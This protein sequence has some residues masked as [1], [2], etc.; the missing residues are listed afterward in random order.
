M[1]LSHITTDLI[2]HDAV[3]QAVDLVRD[4][5]PAN[6]ADFPDAAGPALASALIRELESSALIVTTRQDR[7]D[8]LS[9]ALAEYL[10]TDY[11]VAVWNAPDALPYEQLPNDLE[12]GVRRV[13][14]LHRMRSRDTNRRVW[15]APVNGLMQLLSPPAALADMTLTLRLASRQS[16]DDLHAWATRVGYETSPIVQEPGTIARRGGIVDI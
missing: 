14:M 8:Y 4:G 9:I 16:V 15:V 13:Q 3:R 7:A 1:S 2:Q 11:E 6:I 12:A 10:G 5:S